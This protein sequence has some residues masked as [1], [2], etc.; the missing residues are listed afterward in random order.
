MGRFAVGTPVR[1]V[2]AKWGDRPHWEFSATWLGADQHGEWLGIPA[3]TLFTRPGAT[4]VSPVDQ[5]SLVPSATT[6]VAWLAT[7]HAPGGPVQ[8]YADVATRATWAGTEVRAVDLDLDVVRM[9]DGQVQVEDEDEFAEHAVA[10]AYP[11]RVVRAA[12]ATC[13][14]LQKALDQAQPPF[15]PDTPSPWL[16]KGHIV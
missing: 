6:E 4:Y 9:P 3:G 14:L 7:F 2:L 11:A 5:V 12:E 16:A 8:V 1:M 15:D 13:R 10:F